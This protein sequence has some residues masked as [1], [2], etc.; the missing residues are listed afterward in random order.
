VT[1]RP[2]ARRGE[3]LCM[4]HDLCPAELLVAAVVDVIEERVR[5]LW[6]LLD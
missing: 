3:V 2:L 6:A 4:S 5:G 1:S